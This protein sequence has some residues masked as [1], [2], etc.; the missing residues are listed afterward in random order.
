MATQV[1]G[2]RKRSRWGAVLVTFVL[3]FAVLEL[4]GQASSIWSSP[5]GSQ[6]QHAVQAS[7][8]PRDLAGFNHIPPGCWPKYGCRS[9]TTSPRP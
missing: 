6:V 8:S 4:V 9:G 1:I 7:L 2:G 3:A 5:S